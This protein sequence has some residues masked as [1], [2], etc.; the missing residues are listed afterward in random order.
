MLHMKPLH[1]KLL[2]L[3]IQPLRKHIFFQCLVLL[4]QTKHHPMDPFSTIFPS[5]Q[6]A[7]QKL[8]PLTLIYLYFIFQQN[9]FDILHPNNL[10]IVIQFFL[11]LLYISFLL[12]HLLMLILLLYS[13]FQ[14]LI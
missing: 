8:S 3:F 7:L 10:L 9:Y 1:Y 5:F 13:Y 11:K 2:R 14:H 4:Y 12:N 6:N